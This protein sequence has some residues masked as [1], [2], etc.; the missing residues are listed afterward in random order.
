[1]QHSFQI[2]LETLFDSI[3]N[4]F[5]Q[6]NEFHHPCVWQSLC[7]QILWF[8]VIPEQPT[9]WN[10]DVQGQSTRSAYLEDHPR[11]RKCLITM[12]IVS[13]L[14]G[15]L[16]L[17]NGLN[18]LWMGVTN[19]LRVL[20]WSS[21]QPLIGGYGPCTVS[22]SLFD[23]AAW[24]AR[25]LHVKLSVKATNAALRPQCPP[26]LAAEAKSLRI[27]VVG[28]L[29]LNAT[30]TNKRNRASSARRSTSGKSAVFPWR[31]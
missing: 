18:G 23:E 10:L 12:V 11:T 8:F 6:V 26:Q 24:S 31:S 13:P 16:P 17:P 7:W 22:R 19:H 4:G 28:S 9:T 21:K 5:L 2:F 3:L 20:G 25:N 15:F 14:T 30:Q 27:K 1:M 29:Q